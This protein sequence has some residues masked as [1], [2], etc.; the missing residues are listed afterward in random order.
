MGYYRLRSTAE[1]TDHTA[2]WGAVTE[3][4]EVDGDGAPVRQVNVYERTRFRDRFDRERPFS[5]NALGQRFGCLRAEPLVLAALESNQIGRE[6]FELVW[7]TGEPRVR[8]FAEFKWETLAEI[9]E[10]IQGVHEILW[11]ANAWYPRA[12]ASERLAM[13]ERVVREL[14]AEGLANL[15]RDGFSSAPT[16]IPR[17]EHDSVLRAW[18]TWSLP[19]GHGDATAAFVAITDAGEEALNATDSTHR[20]P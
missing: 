3:F 13:A 19:R 8:E 17:E 6:E 9:S 7:T 20:L 16:P 14:L 2:G 4:F 18:V 10:D 1:R 11:T 5:E 12:S 15:V